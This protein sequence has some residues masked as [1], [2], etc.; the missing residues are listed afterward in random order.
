MLSFATCNAARLRRFNAA[1]A[2]LYGRRRQVCALCA[3]GGSR[4]LAIRKTRG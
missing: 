2:E 3:S 1:F 4:S